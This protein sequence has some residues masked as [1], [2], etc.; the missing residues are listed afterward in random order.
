MDRT[1]NI[2][3]PQVLFHYPGDVNN[4]NYHHRV[5]LHKIGGGKWVVLSPDL[6]LSGAD[7]TTQRHVVLG[8]HSFFPANIFAECYV[9]DELSRGELDR[10]RRLAKT[11]GSILDDSEVTGVQ[12]L[13][14][15]VADPCSKQ[16]GKAL[17]QELLEDVITLGQHGLVQWD[18]EV[19]YLQEIPD[20][21]VEK[22]KEER[23]DATGDIRTLGDHR[24]PQGKRVLNLQDALP[25]M[26]EASLDDWS[27]TGPRSV[28]DYLRAIREGPGDLPTYHLSWVRSSGVAAGSAIAHEHRSLC[29]TVRLAIS[30][31]QLDVSNLCSFENL[32]RRL[33]TLEVAVS[34]S[35]GAPDFTGL[36]V[37]SEAPISAH[38]TAQ[39]SAMNSWITEKLK[40]K[41][42]IQKQSRL[43]REEF[44][45][46]GNKFGKGDE[47]DESGGR[48]RP[49][50][51]KKS[52]GQNDGGGGAAGSTAAA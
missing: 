12:A 40:E 49:K 19:V 25:L 30:K 14:W 13:T 41:A 7:L 52:K 35:P 47:D 32:V 22:F 10:Q 33:I 45:K 2:A 43:F 16:F 1:L 15:I 26:T 9:F 39:V 42:N 3:D 18:D 5:L 21:Q 24:D 28:K 37:I 11:M 6:E 29:E 23:K 17:P 20:D 4:L 51:N 46:G 38:G 8:R 27:F 34:R 36:E 31:D 44:R 48:W 50:K